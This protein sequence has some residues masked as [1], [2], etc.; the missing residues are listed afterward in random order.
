MSA[1]NPRLIVPNTRRRDLLIAL[2]CGLVVLVL[3]LFGVFVLGREQ[4]ALSAN[5][6]SG[7]IV[8]KH[9]AGEKET[10]VS[11]GRKG[12]KSRVTDSGYSFDVRVPPEN[13]VYQLPVSKGLYDS[14]KV[15]D[16]QAFIKPRSEQQ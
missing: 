5:E 8:A 1:P 12:L 11:Y 15:G 16:H 2:G 10:E 4:G 3:I 13:R 6:L 14:R 9:F 7:V